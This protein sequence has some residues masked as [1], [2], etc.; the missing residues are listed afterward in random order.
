MLRST[1]DTNKEA[2]IATQTRARAHTHTQRTGILVE[3]PPE[4]DAVAKEGGQRGK[5]L[6]EDRVFGRWW[7]RQTP[8][9]AIA[10]VDQGKGVEA[11]NTFNRS[12]QVNRRCGVGRQ[13]EVGWKRGG[14]R[15]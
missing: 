13:K 4:V 1:A 7:H 15:G 3:D 5:G 11:Q 10:R 12:P 9:G 6:A 2:H 8:R 14:E